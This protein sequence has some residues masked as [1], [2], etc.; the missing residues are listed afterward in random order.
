MIPIGRER[1][2]AVTTK[3]RGRRILML[4]S[5]SFAGDTRVRNEA[6]KLTE[7]GYAVRVLC[8]DPYERGRKLERGVVVYY[9]RER[10]FFRK[11]A[12]TSA[13]IG[14]MLQHILTVVGY[15][16]EYLYFSVL[17][18][19]L[20]PVVWIRDGCDV[21]H[22]HNPP[23][24][25]SFVAMAYRALGRKFVFDHHDLEPELFLSRFRVTNGPIYRLLLGLEKLS[26]RHA[27]LVLATNDSYKAIDIARG[28]VNRGDV[29][30][31]R[32]GPDLGELLGAP[33][34]TN[35]SNLGTKKL[36]YVGEIAPQ[37]GVD[38]L[39][40]AMHHLL[41]VLKRDD[42]RC[43]IIGPGDAVADLARYAHEL[44]LDG[45]V[46]FTGFIPK[47]ELRCHLRTCDVCLDPNPSSPL[48]DHSTWIK[49]MEYMAFAKPT[50]SFD[51]KETRFTAGAAAFYVTPNSVEEYARAV[52]M[53]MDDPVRRKKMGD[54]G[55]RRIKDVLAWDHV[56]R[57][58]ISAYAWLFGD[59]DPGSRRKQ[60]EALQRRGR[61]DRSWDG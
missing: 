6:F 50:V 23:N 32:N 17:C 53:L 12:R 52:A 56:S 33:K 46:E 38:Y 37:D 31:V 57:E 19:F 58:L 45:F 61:R 60:S 15:I 39:L 1:V 29:F 43:V 7:H 8:L 3:N 49:V 4:L 10:V 16:L 30:V 44:E 41:Y 47:D 27:D 54:C 25:I 40:E 24:V 26:V 21:I 55:Y 59:G 42:F 13:P 35:V 18:F 2:T 34:A 11:N 51:L 36:V 9:L 22:V 5:K 48:N 20:V 28:G 14:A